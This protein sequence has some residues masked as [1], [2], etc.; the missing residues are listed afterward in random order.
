[1]VPWTVLVHPAVEQW[2]AGLDESSRR[3]LAAA[4]DVLS[5]DVPSLGR[6][7]TDTIHGGRHANLKELRPCSAGR[8]EIRVLFAFDPARQ[9]ILLIAGDKAGQW[10]K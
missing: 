9:A 7:F 2:R 5:A 1:V 6:P 4:L 10:A 3:K 8:S